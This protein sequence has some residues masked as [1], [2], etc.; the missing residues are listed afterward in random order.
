MEKK[1]TSGLAVAGLVIGIIALISSVVPLLNLF[2]FPLVL[3]AIIFGGIAVFQTAKG[4]RGGK[5]LAIAGLVLGI[6]GLLITVGMYAGASAASDAASAGTSSGVSSAQQSAPAAG[7]SAD[8]AGSAD[9]AGADAASQEAPAEAAAAPDA[10]YAVTI[11]GAE[12][13]SDYQGNK[14]VIVT[15]TFTNNSDDA[16]NFMTTMTAQAFQD[17]VELE[18]AIM[19]EGV[20]S[21]D[22][23]KDIKPGKSIT[24]KQAYVLAD[25][26][27]DVTV[28]VSE[29]WDFSN[30]LIAEATFSVK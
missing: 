8:A 5:G 10:P 24:V 18:S 23:M 7:S 20:D 29:L 11:D 25:T 19:M 26:E 16:R 21:Q 2:S 1:P 4:K 30:E 12:M 3:L 6:I 28:E 17:G 13:G 9:T 22:L 27:N 15:Y 14:A